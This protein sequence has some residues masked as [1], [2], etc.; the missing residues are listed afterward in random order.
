V[1]VDERVTV[2]PRR[3]QRAGSHWAAILGWVPGFDNFELLNL[4]L[5]R[6]EAA[7]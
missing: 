2:C 6:S 7:H 1:P 3:T 4:R 5:T